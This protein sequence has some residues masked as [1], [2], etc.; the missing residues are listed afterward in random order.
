MQKQ[1]EERERFT[2]SFT[3]TLNGETEILSDYD[4]TYSDS[5]DAVWYPSEEGTYTLR[6]YARDESGQEVSTSMRY[7]IYLKEYS[8]T[9]F[10]VNLQS[11]QPAGTELALD[12]RSDPS[13]WML[14]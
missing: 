8:F 9:S 11:P 3:A 10:E 1:M 2:T 14:L 12:A 13:Y 7:E 6:A 5:G 4:Y